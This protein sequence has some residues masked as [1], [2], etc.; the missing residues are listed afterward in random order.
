MDLDA[1]TTLKPARHF[2]VDLIQAGKAYGDAR[3]ARLDR[4]SVEEHPH[5]RRGPDRP[6]RRLPALE[7]LFEYAQTGQ[8]ERDVLS[9]P[10]R[11]AWRDQPRG[12]GVRDRGPRTRGEDRRAVGSTRSGQ[13]GATKP[14]RRTINSVWAGAS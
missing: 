4:I 6:F 9:G 8:P 14:A 11:I 3:V 10:G 13:F 1:H 5:R 12:S 2:D 7:A